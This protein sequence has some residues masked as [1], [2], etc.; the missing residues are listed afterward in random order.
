MNAKIGAGVF[1]GAAY[2]N[3]QNPA[4]PV[5]SPVWPG[6]R[7]ENAIFD[8]R[9]RLDATRLGDCNFHLGIS[10]RSTQYAEH[11]DEEDADALCA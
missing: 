5:A 7:P 3:F 9:D 1:W 11:R 2:P 4:S 8:R 10:I 6:F